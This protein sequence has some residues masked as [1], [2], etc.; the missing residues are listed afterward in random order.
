M[1][2]EKDSVQIEAEVVDHDHPQ[3]ELVIRR[4]SKIIGHTQ[5]IK[6]MCEEGRPCN[7]ILTQIAAV[8]SALNGAGRL[9]LQDHIKHCVV[10]AVQKGDEESLEALDKAIAKLMK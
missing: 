7:D 2:T 10:D 6:R 1:T 9:I 5:A 4:L 3:M 8:R